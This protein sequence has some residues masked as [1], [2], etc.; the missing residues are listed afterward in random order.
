MLIC[1]S[2]RSKLRANSNADKV[3]SAFRSGASK[4]RM[5]LSSHAAYWWQYRTGSSESWRSS[6]KAVLELD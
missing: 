1:R 5:R 4:S 2:W 6:L 3:F